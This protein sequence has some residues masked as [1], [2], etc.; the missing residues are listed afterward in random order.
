MSYI[1]ALSTAR[2]PRPIARLLG[3]SSSPGEG[4][5]VA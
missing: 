3:H 1:A 4:R 5:R 2:M